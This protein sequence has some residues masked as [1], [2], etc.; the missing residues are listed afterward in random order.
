MLTFF[1]SWTWIRILHAYPDPN[2]PCV[3]GSRR[4]SILQIRIHTTNTIIIKDSSIFEI[5]NL[6]SLF[7]FSYRSYI[8]ILYYFSLACV[9][10]TGILQGCSL[11]S[12]QD[13]LPNNCG[14]GPRDILNSKYQPSQRNSLTKRG[15]DHRR[16]IKTEEKA[17][18]DASVWGEEFIR[19]LAVLAVLHWMIWKIGWMAPGWFERNGWINPILQNRPRQKS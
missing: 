8:C 1:A 3:S 7:C 15:V 17:K 4:P 19:L 13:Q 5:P 6:A 11:F 14:P 9:T 12:S 18:V 10:S 2:T 16:S